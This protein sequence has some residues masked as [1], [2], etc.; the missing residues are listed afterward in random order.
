[1]SRDPPQRRRARARNGVAPY[2]ASLCRD[3]GSA[4]HGATRGRRDRLRSLQARGFASGM[5]SPPAGTAPTG[6]VR[7]SCLPQSGLTTES[8]KQAAGTEEA[9]EEEQ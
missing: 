2:P 5:R 4:G 1:M 6:S 8:R 3:A 7:D 9:Q